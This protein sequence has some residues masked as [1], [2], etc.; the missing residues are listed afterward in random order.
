MVTTTSPP[1]LWGCWKDYGVNAF[2]T[3]KIIAIATAQWHSRIAVWCWHSP[4]L[5]PSQLS[6]FLHSH[7][8]VGVA[9]G[10]VTLCLSWPS[11]PTGPAGCKQPAWSR[12]FPYDHKTTQRCDQYISFLLF[13]RQM[14]YLHHLPII[15]R[16]PII[17]REV[18]PSRSS[19][20]CSNKP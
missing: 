7:G 3:L 9:V 12:R 5:H 14:P 10:T 18:I 6:L 4:H 19:Y 2:E 13:P 16:K 20:T 8:N 17:F 1:I 15:T 11:R